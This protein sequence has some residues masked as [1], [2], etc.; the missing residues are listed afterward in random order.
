VEKGYVYVYGVL[1][2][3]ADRPAGVGIAA[4]PLRLIAGDGVAGLVSDVPDGALRMGRDE[5]TAHARVLEAA[6]ALGTVLPMSFGVVMA[7]D[8]EVRRELL[9]AHRDELRSQLLDLAGKVEL[10]VRAT[11]EEEALM[12][13][14]LR[15]DHVVARV[16][17]SLRGTPVEATYYDRIRLGELVAR[18]V[19]RKREGD[20]SEIVDALAPL[21]L[22][23]EVAEPAHERIVVIA[24]FLVERERMEDFDVAV[25]R[26]GGAQVGRMR[27][28]YTG[29]L[30]PH[31][32]AELR[33]A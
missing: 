14:V 25:E 13:E 33:G 31:S 10:R 26:L 32:F 20:A 3:S 4:A 24:S 23:A 21:A 30:P 29:P 15:E 9:E 2:D 11:Y 16:R 17:E 18:A 22:A 6:I 7:G 5:L 1:P 28:N 12:R 27:L 19:D 8:D